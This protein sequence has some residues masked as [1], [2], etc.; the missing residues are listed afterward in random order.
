VQFTPLENAR[1]Y[2]LS[3][4]AQIFLAGNFLMSERREREGA[5]ARRKNRL[6]EAER[7]E[8]CA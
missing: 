5:K 3:T 4:E 7:T 6:A 8:R 1:Q 2:F